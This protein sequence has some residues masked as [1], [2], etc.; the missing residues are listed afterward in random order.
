MEETILT[1]NK[2][3]RDGGGKQ[4]RGD[5]AYKFRHVRLG[6]LIDM[7]K[8][9]EKY[10]FVLNKAHVR[11]LGDLDKILSEKAALQ[12]EV[13]ILEMKLAE[14]DA[15]VRV[16]NLRVEN[17]LEKLKNEMALINPI[18]GGS[19]D[20]NVD[21][22]QN[23]EFHPLDAISLPP[24]EELSSLR[25]EH[26]SFFQDIQTPTVKL[27]DVEETKER[28]LVLGEEIFLLEAALKE[29]ECRLSTAQEDVSKLTVVK[30]E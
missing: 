9:A 17:P 26:L 6:D 10:I 7:I 23:A 18:E 30:S 13:S 27:S 12:A 29:L 28:V 1:G 24:D 5:E 16:A 20:E 14:T 15:H 8:N 4:N 22:I 3:E 21:K 11:A 19:I 2:D 25:K